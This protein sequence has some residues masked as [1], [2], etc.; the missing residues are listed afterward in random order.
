KKF[1]ILIFT[2][3]LCATNLST[4]ATSDKAETNSNSV[5]NG[6]ITECFANELEMLM[7]SDTSRRFL[8]QGG[9]DPFTDF[10]NINTQTP[11]ANCG[12][13]KYADCIPDPN[14]NL[15]VNPCN[16]YNRCRPHID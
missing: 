3:I 12:R 16:E 14:G 9:K 5:C 10:T 4:A 1:S 13:P 8:Q 6:T 2:I 15:R 11:G 7:D